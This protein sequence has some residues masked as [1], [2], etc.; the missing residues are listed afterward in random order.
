MASGCSLFLDALRSLAH[1]CLVRISDGQ[2]AKNDKQC[3]LGSGLAPLAI[4]LAKAEQ[5][6]EG[7]GAGLALIPPQAV[8]GRAASAGVHEQASRQVEVSKGARETA[9]LDRCVGCASS[10]NKGTEDFPAGTE[11]QTT[12]DALQYN[13]P[14]GRVL[15]SPSSRL[16]SL[17]ALLSALNFSAVSHPVL[18][19]SNVR[20]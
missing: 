15:P 7:L 3:P 14:V 20:Y 17:L 10:S 5:L 9:H 12:S 18:L 19:T 2:S 16:A 4:T 8:P 6:E 11:Q 13:A 1:C